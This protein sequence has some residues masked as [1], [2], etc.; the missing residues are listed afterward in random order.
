MQCFCKTN[1][2]KIFLKYTHPK[3]SETAPLINLAAEMINAVRKGKVSDHREVQYT[4]MGGAPASHIYPPF[5]AL[6]GT[7]RQTQRQE[8]ECHVDTRSEGE[9]KRPHFI[10]L[11]MHVSVI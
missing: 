2:L 11:E 6:Q 3:Y 7:G 9:E 10:S 4:G 8:D 1:S 5:T